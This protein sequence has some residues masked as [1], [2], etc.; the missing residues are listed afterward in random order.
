MDAPET[1]SVHTAMGLL[2]VLCSEEDRLALQ[3]LFLAGLREAE[4]TVRE[5]LQRAHT[6]ELH[7]LY[8]EL[9]ALTQ[10]LEDLSRPTEPP[11]ADAAWRL[12]LAHLTPSEQSQLQTIFERVEAPLGHAQPDEEFAEMS[13]T[14]DLL[15]EPARRLISQLPYV[16]LASAEQSPDDHTLKRR[17]LTWELGCYPE[18]RHSRG[19]PITVQWRDGYQTVVAVLILQAMPPG[20]QWTLDIADPSSGREVHLDLPEDHKRASILARSIEPES[21]PHIAEMTARLAWTSL[22]DAGER[23]LL[24]ALA[25]VTEELG[26]QY[27]IRGASK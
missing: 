2:L 22:L 5:D 18:E 4:Q 12:L 10:R 6:P 26:E 17:T 21:N 23:D 27:V 13:A 14:S 7:E 11:L 3:R 9:H 16:T 1:I 8:D 15:I 19:S 20:A 25:W 24:R